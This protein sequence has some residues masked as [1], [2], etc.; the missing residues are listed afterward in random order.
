MDPDKSTEIKADNLAHCTARWGL[1][2]FAW[3]N[4]GLG[5]IGVVVPGM[6]TTVFLLIAVWAF[7]KC[8]VKFQRWLWEHPRFGPSIRA[9]HLHRVIPLRA[10]IM[11]AGM[12]TLSVVI[13]AV[14]VAKT[15]VMPVVLAVIML[16]ICLYIVTRASEAPEVEKAIDALSESSST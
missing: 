5:L 9:W 16:P 12:M 3:L 13:V 11:A 2:A 4:V 14:F 1:M 15:W 10:K 8:S 6:P 7:S